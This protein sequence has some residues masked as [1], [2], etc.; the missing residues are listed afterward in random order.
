M[1]FAMNTFFGIVFGIIMYVFHMRC[2]N[3][4]KLTISFSYFL[5]Q[6]SE[7]SGGP[8]GWRVINYFLGA[9]TIFAGGLVFA[10]IGTPEEVWWLTKEQKVMARARIVSNAS[11]S[12]SR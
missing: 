9:M 11:M 6:H 8:A 1:F 2:E 12:N 7:T 4:I 10:F 5:A 3:Y